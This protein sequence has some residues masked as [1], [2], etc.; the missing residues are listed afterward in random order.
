MGHEDYRFLEVTSSY[1][2]IFNLK[3]E[4][5]LWERICA[6][7]TDAQRMIEEEKSKQRE[8]P[9]QRDLIEGTGIKWRSLRM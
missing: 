1:R 8:N 5:K 6:E 3:W 4:Q 2:W 9:N 7:I